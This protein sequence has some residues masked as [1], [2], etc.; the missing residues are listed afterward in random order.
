MNDKKDE[1][2]V[3]LFWSRDEKALEEVE[4]RYTGF[5]HS[6]LSSFI[7]IKEDREECVNDALLALWQNIPPERP[8]S[9]TAYFAKILK[10]IALVRTRNENAWKRGGRA[11]QVEDEF[12]KDVS[13]GKTI[14][15]HYDSVVTE[16]VIN[17]FLGSL[18][19][20]DRNIFVLR[21]WF[22]E[23]ICR[24]SQRTGRSVGSITMLLSRL[25]AKLA[26]RLV[27]EGILYE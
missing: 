27:K 2:I 3:E 23:D 18:S 7:T 1:A 12:L 14:M 19:K 11:V 22:E 15:D 17:E 25:R 8:R 4:K 6:I 9:L 24:I 21:Y 10:N 26:K 16:R 20:E 13:D 5:A